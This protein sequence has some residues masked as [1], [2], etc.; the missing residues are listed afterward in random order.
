MLWI[1]VVFPAASFPYLCMRIGFSHELSR[2]G[3]AAERKGDTVLCGGNTLEESGGYNMFFKQRLAKAKTFL[4]SRTWQNGNT[5]FFE[6]F[7]EGTHGHS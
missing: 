3:V 7:S 4:L 5:F 6:N 1:G 2:K